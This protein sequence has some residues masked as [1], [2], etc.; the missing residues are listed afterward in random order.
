MALCRASR[1]Y[2]GQSACGTSF[3]HEGERPDRVAALHG[4][5]AW[6]RV[7]HRRRPTASTRQAVLSCAAART[8]KVAAAVE[9][10]VVGCGDLAQVLETG[11]A[12]EDL[13]RV[14]GVLTD[15]RPLGG[16]ELAGFFKDGVG[17]RQVSPMSLEQR[18]AAHF[19]RLRVRRSRVHARDG[20]G[21]PWRHRQ[22]GDR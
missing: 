5:A 13:Q 2:R 8:A 18:G 4:R 12:L 9:P 1:Q 21:R 20:D 22:S 17:E 3:R 16:V 6:R 15:D 19:E 11:N 10:L 14:V 7:R